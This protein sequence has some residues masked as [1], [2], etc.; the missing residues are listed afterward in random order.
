MRDDMKMID[1]F[2]ANYT[3][4]KSEAPGF[5]LAVMKDGRT[6]YNKSYGFRSMEDKTEITEDTCFYIASL[7]KSFTAAAIMLLYEQSK[8]DLNDN[9]NKYFKD[10]P[11]HYDDVKIINIV[12]HTSGIK[13]YFTVYEN[14]NKST[15]NMTN[16]DVYDFILREKELEY[17][18]NSRFG[19]SNTAYVLLALLIE[20]LSGQSFSDFLEHN[21]FKP[22]GMK[23]TFVFTEKTQ[24]IPNRAYGYKKE[25]DK[26]CD[27]D[28][29]GLTTGDGGIYSTINDLKLWMAA[30]ENESIFNKD[31]IDK[32]FTSNKLNDGS[33]GKYG[34]GW[35][36]LE[37]DNVKVPFHSGH[38]NGFTNIILKVPE[39]KVSIIIL[40][41]YY[42]ECW[43]SIFKNCTGFAM[44]TEEIGSK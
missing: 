9:I 4:N 24:V 16:A 36:I 15:D 18:C 10:L 31:I 22:L 34:F 27:F 43:Q 14:N 23:N 28:Y 21:F 2:I 17:P 13:D 3:K 25:G 8:L 33:R 32:I 1:E 37:E 5:S 35:F 6:V 41:N 19:Y 29:C 38:Y 7:A 12:N 20:K 42:E 44:E 26:F 39:E 40:T 11:Q 30:F